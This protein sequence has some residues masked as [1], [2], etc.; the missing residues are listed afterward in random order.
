MN[1]WLGCSVESGVKVTRMGTVTQG[2]SAVEHVRAPGGAIAD[3]FTELG[4]LSPIRVLSPRQCAQFLQAVTESNARPEDWEKG[5]AVSSRLFY[6]IATHPVL[7]E[8]LTR[9]LGEDVMLWGAS[10]ITRRPGEIHPWHSD[11][12]SSFAPPGKTV[13]VWMGMQHTSRDSSLLVIPY[14]HRF[15]IT[16]QEVRHRMGIGRAG[17]TGEAVLEWARQQDTRCRLVQ[18]EMTDGDA[19]FFDGQIWHGSQNSSGQTRQALLLQYATPDVKIRIPDL[20]HLDWPFRQRKFRRPACM[21]VNGKAKSRVN[22]IVSAPVAGGGGESSPRLTGRIC[23]FHVPLAPDNQKGWKPYHIF[24]GETDGLRYLSCHASVLN[25]GHRPHPPHA[26]SEEE[27]LLLLAGEADLILPAEKAATGSERRRLRPGQFVYYPAHFAHTLETVSQNPAS[28]MM[29]KWYSGSAEAGLP[30]RFGQF[31][32]SDQ[33]SHPNA[34][35]GFRLRTLFE[36]PTEYLQ[37]LHCHTSTLTPGA[38]YE[39]HTDAYD[40]AIIVL[41]GEIETLGGRA[42]PHSVIFYRAGEP[43]GMHNP[44]EVV[45]KYIVFE[46]HGSRDGLLDEGSSLFAKLRNPR[47]VRRKVK[48]LVKRLIKR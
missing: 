38:G 10:I 44:G 11:I 9:L 42:S 32:F 14:S 18:S 23:P 43:H 20:N 27:L 46:F 35:D 25:H 33:L 22:R 17:A 34:E 48:H 30:L 3:Q 1:S 41:E 40:V 45:A 28:Y 31:D 36:G 12:E 24:E 16:V 6:E 21:M 29:F 7:I 4:Y 13:S 2:T 37:N 39:P 15:G 8:T 19:L 26:H 47:H 5:N